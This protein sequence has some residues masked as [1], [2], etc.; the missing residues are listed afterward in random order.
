[1]S[2]ASR[3]RQDGLTLSTRCALAQ[4]VPCRNSVQSPDDF[5][6]DQ[7]DLDPSTVVRIAKEVV[8]DMRNPKI[9]WNGY[10]EG[11]ARIGL[12]LC[13][14]ELEKRTVGVG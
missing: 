8:A 14:T 10:L 3:L 7:L 12:P 2:A 11:L 5:L 6:L 4:V 13:A 9:T 1:M